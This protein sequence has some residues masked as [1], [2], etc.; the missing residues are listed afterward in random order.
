MSTILLVHLDYYDP[1]AGAVATWRGCTGAGFVTGTDAAYRPP[2]VPAHVWYEPRIVQ[3]ASMRRD[4]F[5]R[6]ATGGASQ[7]GYGELIVGNVDGGLDAWPTYGFD[8]RAIEIL[9]GEMSP[10]QP[11]SW[12][13]V[14]RGTM[15]QP[16]FGL[17][18]IAIRLRDRQAELDLPAL[19]NRYRG[20]NEL[21]EGLDG[22][23]ADLAGRPIPGAWGR[24][25]NVPA[26]LVNT[27]RL[28]YQC[29]G[30]AVAAYDRGAALTR[31]A[32]YADQAAM[33]ATAPAAAQYR[34]WPAGGY[35]RLGSIP[36]GQVTFDI[37]QG[38][39]PAN[40]TAAQV[41]QAILTGPG[42]I[43]SGDIVAADV[44]ALDA[45]N[46][47]E[48]GLWLDADTDC[49]AALDQVL[50][51][52]G[53]WWGCDRLGQF[54]MAR[55]DAPQAAAAVAT[56]DDTVIDD[57]ERVPTSDDGNGL[58]AW[59]VTL[60][61]SRKWLT[62]ESDLAGSVSDARRAEL[63]EPWQ[64]VV[65]EDPAVKTAHPLAA[66]LAFDSLLADTAAA[67]AEADRKLALHKVRRDRYEVACRID[68]ALAETLDLGAVVLLQIPRYDLADGKPM[69][70][71]GIQ[72]DLRAALYRLTL[73]G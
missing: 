14:L 11:P 65:A 37:E 26:P 71:I 56:L 41:A 67:Q 68:A 54:R 13:T 47:G 32:D 1:V 58:P 53:A 45:A 6:G 7:V 51:S 69:R 30:T 64:T 55:I 20:S 10:M 21:P 27:S 35:A 44:A 42:G 46:A 19:P 9:L 57:I 29:G 17:D 31:G 49:R 22:T 23:A 50:A 24:A 28:I 60:R 33:E 72:A 2:G 4:C 48:I 38:A 34:V 18:S 52:V 12:T 16:R 59:R 39:A 36:A 43:A 25:Y 15:E 70:V 61:Y 5:S 73:W 66:D 3:P 8:A 62:Q 40:R 63:R